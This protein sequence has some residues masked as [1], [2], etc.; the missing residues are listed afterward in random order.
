[1]PQQINETF[2]IEEGT[3]SFMGE[4]SDE[5]YKF[6]IQQGLISLINQGY[7]Q[8]DFVTPKDVH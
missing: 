5:E 3:V 4:V 6:I 2:E 8:P 1:M 7:I